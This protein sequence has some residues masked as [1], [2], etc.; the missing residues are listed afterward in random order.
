M[1]R[2]DALSIANAG[3][4]ATELTADSLQTLRS[5]LGTFE[6]TA[7]VVTSFG[8]QK[9]DQD[10]YD[11]LKR[12]DQIIGAHIRVNEELRRMYGKLQTLAERDVAQEV[13]DM[14]NDLAAATVT[15]AQATGGTDF[16][17]EQS[18][19]LSKLASDTAGLFAE[20]IQA[21][22]LYEANRHFLSVIDLVIERLE[23]RSGAYSALFQ[24]AVQ[25][26]E[27]LGKG[28]LE[29]RYARP[30]SLLSTYA[31]RTGL[32]YDPTFVDMIAFAALL[33][34]LK[35]PPGPRPAGAEWREVLEVTN[36][37]LVART[38]QT[39]KLYDKAIAESIRALKDLRVAH[40]AVKDHKGVTVANLSYAVV[41][42][43]QVADSVDSFLEATAD[44]RAAR[45]AENNEARAARDAELQK[46]L[47]QL[48]SAYGISLPMGGQ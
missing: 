26:E 14:A 47:E 16:T 31:D 1:S 40:L 34:D 43:R 23:Q 5:R 21:R 24:V 33:E 35:D 25:P 36:Q 42:L 29:R 38:D 48:L 17:D 30:H 28:L 9:P 39:L 13:G 22:H 3:I 2:P 46:L 20:A 32:D 18:K 27:W 19:S 37:A 45:R 12:A 44:A 8:Y 41:R 10:Q 15:L 6:E 11:N 7:T 4:A